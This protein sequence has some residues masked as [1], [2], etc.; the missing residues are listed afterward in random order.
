LFASFYSAAFNG[1][2]TDTKTLRDTAAVAALQ[3]QA[4]SALSKYLQGAYPTQPFR[5][6]K[7]LLMLPSLQS[8]SASTI[9]ALFFR[10]TIGSIAIEKLLVDLYMAGGG[11]AGGGEATV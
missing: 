9:E 11:I 6:G 1:A 10:R 4:Q 2:K 7:L 3:D 5:F 8:V